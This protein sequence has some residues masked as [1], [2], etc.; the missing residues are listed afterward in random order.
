MGEADSRGHR[1]A[2]LKPPPSL[3]AASGC[4]C[5]CV[6]VEGRREGGRVRGAARALSSTKAGVAVA[7]R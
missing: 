3:M 1:G 5:V 4:V 2:R 6:C 7:T